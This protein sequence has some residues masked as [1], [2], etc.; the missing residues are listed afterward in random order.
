MN[1]FNLDNPLM[2]FLGK[3]ADLFI[4]NILYLICCIPIVTIGAATTALYTVTLKAAKNEESYIT[5]SF[6]RAFKSNFKIGTLTWLIVLTAGIVLWLDL[7]IIPNISRQIRQVLQILVL[8]IALLYLIT[9]LYLFP[10]IARFENTVIGSIKNAFLM[11]VIHLPYT[12]LLAAITILAFMATLYID[13]RII[14]FLWIVIGFSGLA[15]INSIFFR[16][17][18]VKFE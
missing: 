17:I 5:R 7:Q 16:K 3:L 14:G 1:L 6:F 9:A 15:Y 12:M 11:A 10:Y 4:L 8:M 2:Q 13:F 18:F